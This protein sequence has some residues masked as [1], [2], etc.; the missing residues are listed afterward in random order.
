MLFATYLRTAGVLVLL[1]TAAGAPAQG[2]D[3]AFVPTV[4]YTAQLQ[5]GTVRAL[6]QQPDG[7][8]LVAGNFILV[9]NWPT[10]NVA[11]LAADGQADNTFTAPAVAGGEVLA[12]APDAQGRVLLVGT[13]A[14]V[15]GQP[16][17]GVAR[18]LASGALDPTF[19]PVLQGSPGATPIVR[20]VVVQPDGKLV[21]GGSF[22]M[23]GTGSPPAR[24]VVRLLPS[25]LPDAG[26]VPDMPFSGQV[27]ALLL[28]P[29]G[30]LLVAGN[31]FSTQLELVRRLLPTGS[32]D[33]AFTIVPANPV[34]AGI[35][36]A[37]APTPTGFVLGGAFVGVGNVA[38][39]SV[40]RFLAN[41]VLDAAFASPLPNVMPAANLTAVAAEA[42]GS[43]YVGG[44]MN[45]VGL[46]RL[47]PSGSFDGAYF[48]PAVTAGP[49]GNVAA[50]VL[51]PD[52]KLLVGGAF[53]R[54]GGQRRDGLARL[55]DPA[56]LAA[57]AAR[58]GAALTAY[59]NP[60]HGPLH[61]QLDAAAGPRRVVLLDALGREVLA[62]LTGQTQLTLPTATLLPGL[63]E[64]RVEYARAGPVTRRVVVE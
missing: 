35:G 58:P 56:A 48:N 26:F 42:G 53:Q 4:T 5:P 38:R 59:P 23:P 6:C 46:R 3:P 21:L 25:G 50:L 28:L 34:V 36:W 7:H 2:L 43:T 19:A 15:G 31:I 40:A 61:L 12:V 33:P 64:L 54:I 22:I 16:R 62:L 24:H 55:L 14:A 63:Y 47:L 20:A 13:F 39:A 45:T 18:L 9:N 30:A 8:I 29:T 52:G 41:G 51:Q 60:V 10:T 11:R 27:G 57:A 44:E 1:G 49:D 37:L 32:L 17:A